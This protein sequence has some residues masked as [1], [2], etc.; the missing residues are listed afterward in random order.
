MSVATQIIRFGVM[1]GR[2]LD[3]QVGDHNGGDVRLW[4]SANQQL[5][6][7]GLLCKREGMVL[8]VRNCCWPPGRY[9]PW[10]RGLSPHDCSPAAGLAA[11]IT[12]RADPDAPGMQA[13]VRTGADIDRP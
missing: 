9:R 11:L 5:V 6:S 10:V 2:H 12:D 7:T 3:D 1:S 4:S 13:R 8:L